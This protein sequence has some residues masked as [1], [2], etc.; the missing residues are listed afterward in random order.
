MMNPMQ[1]S[2]DRLPDFHF[3][4]IAPNLGAEWLFD[5]ARQYWDRF[6]P[7]V[8]SDLELV[9][10]VPSNFS[11]AVTMIARRDTVAQWGVLLAQALPQA[12][13]DMVVYDYFEDMKQA[14]N[15]RAELGQ[16]FGVPLQPTTVP[17]TPLQ[18]TPGP[19]IGGNQ[20]VP[21]TPERQGGFV[22]ATPTPTPDSQGP[23]YPTPGPI[24]G[25]GG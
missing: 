17:P 11:V 8:V 10:L 12:L 15:R 24:T 6:R 14:L 19:I 16:P 2:P 13:P 1:A 5:A 20:P 18:P 3:L 4:L 7:I 23:I 21:S 9:R 22:T 25:N